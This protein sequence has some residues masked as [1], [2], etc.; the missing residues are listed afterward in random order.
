[1]RVPRLLDC[2]AGCSVYS[3]THRTVLE[4]LQR[5]CSGLAFEPNV[6]VRVFP[7]PRFFASW[8]WTSGAFTEMCPSAGYAASMLASAEPAQLV[9]PAQ[10]PRPSRV[11]AL[12]ADIVDLARRRAATVAAGMLVLQGPHHQRLPLRSVVPA[13]TAPAASRRACRALPDATATSLGLR[14]HRAQARAMLGTS[15]WQAAHRQPPR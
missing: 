1:V 5:N 2:D 12:L 7:W 9:M 6:F 11:S 4:R 3:Q 14:R 10:F 13:R 15:A 8:F